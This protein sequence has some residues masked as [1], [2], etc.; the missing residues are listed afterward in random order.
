MKKILTFIV[1]GVVVVMALTFAAY[2]VLGQFRPEVEMRRMA[3]AMAGL[4]SFSH[5]A[6]FSWD[7]TT[8]YT[9]G[10][11]HVDADNEVECTST[12]RVVHLTEDAY[13]DL[14]GEVK[15]V[16]NKTYL[17]YTPPGPDVP[18]VSFDEETWV[19]FDEGEIT[20]WGEVIP[21]LDAPI[22][23]ITS[24]FGWE[25]EAVSRLRSVLTLTDVAMVEYDGQT[26]MINNVNTRVIDG[27]FDVEA[28]EGFLLDLT[29]AKTGQEAEDEDRIVA[30]TQAVQLASLK[31][32]FWIGMENHLLYRL[33]AG[34]LLDARLEFSAFNEAINVDAPSDTVSFQEILRA[35]LPESDGAT[36]MGGDGQL[37]TTSSARLPVTRVEQSSDADGDG[38]DDLLEAFYGT[39]R[40][41]AD[42]DGDGISDGQEVRSGR[43]PRGNG[44][45]FGF[46]L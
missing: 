11:L 1:L 2:I 13:T 26:E 33:Q 37:V 12:F 29:R 18:G 10:S 22:M 34:A 24:L 7:R 16:G 5:D 36:L 41:K 14:S 8:L 3:I 28:V 20:G 30:H 38:L 17:T 25:P 43:N 40:G 15:S 45:L 44:T 19:E 6:G 39:D 9:T 4:T 42:T 35:A 31:L 21:G 23:P 46:G 32:R 27:T